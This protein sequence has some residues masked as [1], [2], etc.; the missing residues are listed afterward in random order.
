MAVG[1]PTVRNLYTGTTSGNLYVDRR[2]FYLTPAQFSELFAN[3]AP[4]LTFS[5]NANFRTG[6]Q[7][8]VFK[9]LN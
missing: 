4:F 6:L 7:D 3:V 9:L 8:P 5:M 2:Q 1:A